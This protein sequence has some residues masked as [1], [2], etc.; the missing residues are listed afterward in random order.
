[1]SQGLFGGRQTSE[2]RHGRYDI[3]VESIDRTFSYNIL[4]LDQPKIC[5]SLPRIRD[6]DLIRELK[7]RGIELNDVGPEIPPIEML[8]FLEE[9]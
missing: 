6:S 5:S 8:I 1:M 4:V 7:F 3:T 9:Y 2:V